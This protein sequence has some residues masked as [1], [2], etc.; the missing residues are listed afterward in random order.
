MLFKWATSD[1]SSTCGKVYLPSIPK[2]I[3][4][5]SIPS[6]GVVGIITNNQIVITSETIVSISSYVASFKTNGVSVS[7]N[8]VQ[9][10]SG[11]TLN[12]Y[13]SALKYVV[14]GADGSTNE[15]T[16]QMVAP[17]VVGSGSLRLW[18]KADQL[19]L[20]DGDPVLTWSDVSGYGNHVTQAAYPTVHTLFRKGQVNGYPIAEFR[21]SDKS[22]MELVTGAT[23]LYVNASGSVFFVMKL[24]QT[25]GG[26][27]TLLNLDGSGGR[28]IAINNPV[29]D[30]FICKNAGTCVSLS[31]LPIPISKFLA[32]GSVQILTTNVRIYWNGILKGQLPIT[33]DYGGANPN[34]LYLGNGNLDI[35]LAEMLYFNTDL[36]EAEVEKVFFYL[37][38][39]YGLTAL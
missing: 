17:R 35:D 13:N 26:G 11:E 3:L 12:D 29:S 9:Q 34:S 5:Y 23:G 25:V 24:I 27:V 18:F 32:I 38:T 10:T 6:L 8:G 36:S 19:T 1:N 37:N 7:V 21:S 33:T 22:R 28:E 30:Y 20:N 39:K 15:Y 16:V 4:E 14:T 31:G 2:E